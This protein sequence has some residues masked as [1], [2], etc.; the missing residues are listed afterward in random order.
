MLVALCFLAELNR[1]ASIDDKHTISTRAFFPCPPPD[2]PTPTST[3]APPT[4]STPPTN[5]TTIL[6]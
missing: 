2:L 3:L 1:Q 6:L 5:P 4:T